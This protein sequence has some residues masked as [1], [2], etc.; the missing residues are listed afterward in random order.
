MSF[1]SKAVLASS[2]NML[3][4]C[5]P[6]VSFIFPTEKVPCL[7]VPCR[8][9]RLYNSSDILRYLYG[10]FLPRDPKMVEFLKPTKEAVELEAK[11]D[12]FALDC[13][14][15][16]GIIFCIAREIESCVFFLKKI[17]GS[18]TTPW[19][20][21]LLEGT[22]ARSRFGATTRTGCQSGRK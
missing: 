21:P 16:G 13:R 10:A 14:R 19:W 1:K 17:G 11:I 5:F 9:I 2:F 6:K 4:Q 22:S 3:P 8:G 20:S 12:Q 15:W 7:K 18:T